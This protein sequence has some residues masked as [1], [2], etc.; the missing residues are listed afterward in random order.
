MTRATTA[1]LLLMALGVCACGHKQEGP[2]PTHNSQALQPIGPSHQHA[3][4]LAARDQ[5]L[6]AAL[7]FARAKYGDKL[8]YNSASMVQKK[9]NHMAPGVDPSAARKLEA[10]PNYQM[11]ELTLVLSKVPISAP[12]VDPNN[13]NP[14]PISERVFMVTNSMKVTEGAPLHIPSFALQRKR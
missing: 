2:E 6:N 1:C 12:Q 11:W 4:E 5:A 10:D 7:D 3:Q 9:G 8:D 14:F 13:T